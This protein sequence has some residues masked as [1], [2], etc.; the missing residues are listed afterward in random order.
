M[1]SKLPTGLGVSS[2]AWNPAEDPDI[3]EL[4]Q[5]RGVSYIDLVP[6]KY[7]GWDDLSAV[8]KALQIKKKWAE[9]GVNIRGI[10]SLLFG[11]GPLNILNPE[12]WKKLT[13][14]FERVF[15][16]A[17]ALGANRLVFGSP[18]N[19]KRGPMG[20][21]EAESI[22]ADFFRKL[23]D[24]ARNH[25]CMVLLEPNPMEYGC[26]FVTKT[27]EAIS[28]VQKVGHPNL[29]V[30]LDLGTCFYNDEEADEILQ[31]S[32]ESIGYIHL[33]TKNLSA[34]QDNPNPQI[35][36]LLS[37]ILNEQP[38]SIEMMGRVDSRN[39]NQVQGALDWVQQALPPFQKE[40]G[41]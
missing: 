18:N 20:S 38:I 6:T 12:D 37:V 36:K 35:M 8:Q 34:L 10:Q 1:N 3:A 9:F 24:Q 23:A 27:S 4:L 31:N 32:S 25:T 21:M 19:R 5:S 22:A 16:V 28:L 11:A 40:S 41:R 13:A 33:A 2:L 26:D 15:S 30:Q 39:L 17:S 7:F 29:R 14:H